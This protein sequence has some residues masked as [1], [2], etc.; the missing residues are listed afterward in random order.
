MTIK[1]LLRLGRAPR[2]LVVC[3]GNTCRSPLGEYL[4]RDRYQAGRVWS[5]GTGASEGDP[6]AHYAAI[7]IEDLTGLEGVATEHGSAPLVRA[8]VIAAD[9]VIA[10]TQGHAMTIQAA[11]DNLWCWQRPRLVT[12][13]V[14]DPIGGSLKM[15]WDT[16]RTILDQ[17]RDRAGLTPIVKGALMRAW[18]TVRRD[19]CGIGGVRVYLGRFPSYVQLRASLWPVRLQATW[20]KDAR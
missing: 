13:A 11:I 14:P 16:A 10:M 7:V 20:K 1:E 18:I 12:L 4:I 17:V 15:Y 6:I 5:R 19:S 9:V 2:V 3:T 8:D